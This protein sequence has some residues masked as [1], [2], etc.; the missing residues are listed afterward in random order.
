MKYFCKLLVLFLL[1]GCTSPATQLIKGDYD[2]MIAKY[3]KYMETNDGVT[4]YQIAEA[5][6][7]SNRIKN[8]E[9]FYASALKSGIDQDDAYYYYA[10]SLK[11]NQKYDDAREVLSNALYKVKDELIYKLITFE[12]D[13]LVSL[14]D[15][16]GVETFYRTKNLEEINTSGAEYGPVFENGRLYFTSNR[17]GGKIYKSTGT[18]FTDIYSVATQGAKIN[19]R[20]LMP[21]DPIINNPLVNEGSLALGANGT[22]LLFAKGNSGKAS[23]TLEVNIFAARYRNGKWGTPKALNLNDPNAYDG[24]PALNKGGNTLYFASNRAGGFGGADLYTAQLDRRG[25]WVDV[26]NL[27]PEINTPG[28]EMFPFISESGVLYFSS[29]GQPGF[30]NLDVFKATRIGGSMI[31]EN[32]G[33]PMNSSADDFGFYEYNLT[34]GFFSSNRRGGKGDDDIYTFVNDDPNLK[35]INYFLTGN[36]LTM[37]DGG[38]NITVSNTKVSLI[39]G[40]GQILDEFFTQE[41][42]VYKFRVYAEEN[43]NIRVEKPNY[44][45]AR[46]AF[47]TIGRSI[48]R[49]TLTQFQTDITFELDVILDQIVIEKTIV[50]NNIYYD[51][52]KAEIRTDAAFML[53]SLVLILEDNPEIYIE[54][55]SHTDDRNTDEYNLDLSQRRAK[56]AVDYLIGHGIQSKRVLA[57]GYGETKLIIE[58]AKTEADHQINRRTEFKVLKYDPQEIEGEEESEDEY[59]RFF[60]NDNE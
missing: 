55:G 6:R 56:S 60:D 30:G 47:S 51:L 49:D 50:L 53:D 2:G 1:S 58:N 14:D 22:Y 40:E 34:R 12:I 37:D 31:I 39:S 33:T 43:Y 35:I 9:P 59:E 18:P 52:D 25:R 41:D 13:G 29:D 54:L 45:S 5:Y 46:K 42:G 20:T 4:N 17:D 3:G 7:L 10:R 28:N 23:G 38:A 48:R 19:L 57:K 32:L 15:M 24:T 26:R 27:G 21:L 11:A 8:A 44:F 36:T 16:H